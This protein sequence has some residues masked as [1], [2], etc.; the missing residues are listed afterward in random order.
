MRLR[1][2][3][4][5]SSRGRRLSRNARLNRNKKPEELDFSGFLVFL[6]GVVMRI[7]KLP[8]ITADTAL[9]SARAIFRASN[10]KNRL[11]NTPPG[12]SPNPIPQGGNSSFLET[13]KAFLPLNPFALFAYFASLRSAFLT[14]RSSSAA[15]PRVPPAA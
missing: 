13:L 6:V 7:F 15:L 2:R 1:R 4:A 3:S 5:R 11:G 14:L 8:S 9:R 10:P 12:F